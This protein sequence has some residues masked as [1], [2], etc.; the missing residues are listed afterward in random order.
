M[1]PRAIEITVFKKSTGVL[2]KT[3]A[4]AEDGVARLRRQR[5][6]NVVG[7]GETRAFAG[8]RSSAR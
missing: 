1:N 5:V 6:P 3:I 4:A 7:G 2:S 8:R